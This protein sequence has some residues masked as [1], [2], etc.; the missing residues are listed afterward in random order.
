MDLQ[1]RGKVIFIAGA[2]RGIGLGIAEACLREGARLAISARGEEAL[3]DCHAALAGRYGEDSLWSAAGDLREPQTIDRMVG[4]VEREFGPIWGAVANVGLQFAP[5]GYDLDDETWRGGMQQ[6]LDSAYFLARSALRRME[7]RR[8]G[9]VLFVSSIA[10]IDTLKTPVNY[11]PAKAALNHLTKDLAH[12]VGPAGIRV[13]A[14]A[15]GNV[16]FPGGVWDKITKGGTDEKWNR[17]LAREVPLQRFGR[18]G[19]IGD[20]AAFL[21]SPVA[22]FVTGE[23]MKVDGGQTR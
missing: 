12:I 18:P 6:N 10:G 16:L 15:P 11:G 14:I 22:S 17:Y 21:L 1:L 23:V 19:E 5:A 9:A 2:S 8:E 3:R 13:N 20:A 7:P 4:D